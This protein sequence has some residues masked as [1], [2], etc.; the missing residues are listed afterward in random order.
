VVYAGGFFGLTRPV[1]DSFSFV[2]VDKL[3]DVPVKVNNEEIGKTN[4]SGRL[5]IPTMRSYNINKIDLTPDNI[6]LE[7]SIPGVNANILPLLWSGSCVAFDVAKVQAVTGKII[8]KKQEKIIPLE[9]YDVTMIVNGKEFKFPTGRGGEFYFDT[10]SKTADKNPSAQQ[11]GCQ[12]IR[13]KT[14]IANKIDVPGTY[15]ASFDY[16]GKIH[17]FSIVIPPS[18]DSII[19]VGKIVYELQ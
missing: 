7:Y 10:V 9:F 4:A 12:A 19:D 6:P 14:N 5:I 15:Q 1:N 13:E 2:M 16:E 8:L 11:Q 18:S 17:P 3:S